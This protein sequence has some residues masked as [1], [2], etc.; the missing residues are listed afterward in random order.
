[1]VFGDSLSAAYGMD[2]DLG[3]VSLLQ[4]RLERGGYDHRVI[5]VS[6]SGE[7]TSGALS[8]LQRELDRHRPEIVIVELGGNDGLRGLPLDQVARNLM[9]IVDAIQARGARVLLAGMQL[10]PNYGSAYTQG[11]HRIFLTIAEERRTGLVPFLLHGLSHDDRHFLPDGI[12][13]NA[14]AQPLIMEN[15]WPHLELMIEEGA[16]GP[17]RAA[18]PAS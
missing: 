1:M 14:A 3:W 6:L 15:V 8:R 12:H 4:R 7:T 2:Q 17:A 18:F 10:P 16:S 9:R 5:N 11:F 13:P